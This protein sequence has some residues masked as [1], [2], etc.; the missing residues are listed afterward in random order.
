LAAIAL[1]IAAAVELFLITKIDKVRLESENLRLK[2]ALNERYKPSSI[3]GNSKSMQ[4]V[5]ELVGG[6]TA[7]QMAFQNSIQIVAGGAQLTAPFHQSS[8]SGND[9]D[10]QSLVFSD[11]RSRHGRRICRRSGP[12]R[13]G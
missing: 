7:P 6:R 2:N 9:F 12:L 3:I 4:G 10:R 1:M 13:P 5:C 11:V 8:R